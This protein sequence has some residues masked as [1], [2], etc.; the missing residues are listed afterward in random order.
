MEAVQGE[1]EWVDERG[2]RQTR[3][4]IVRVFGLERFVHMTKKRAER[5][6]RNEGKTAQDVMCQMI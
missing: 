3:G 5:E 2:K 6:E 4:S 1:R